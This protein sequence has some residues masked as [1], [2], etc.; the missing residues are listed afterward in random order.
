MKKRSGWKLSSIG[1]FYLL[2]IGSLTIIIQLILGA[3]IIILGVAI[4]IVL[5]SL[6]EIWINDINNIGAIIVF[7]FGTCTVTFG[8][9]LKTILFQRL[10]SNLYDPSLAFFVVLIGMIEIV[11]A[12]TIVNRMYINPIFKPCID[13][14]TLDLIGII[15]FFIGSFT[16]L[17]NQLYSNR[18]TDFQAD[19]PG[20]G[21]FALFRNL[22]ILSVITITASTLLKTEGRKILS[23]RLII[24]SIFITLM[25][26]IDNQKLLLLQPFLAFLL[27]IFFFRK[28]KIPFQFIYGIIGI[29][30][31]VIFISPMV[32]YFRY[33][34]I[35]GQTLENK[36]TLIE[37]TITDLGLP[38]LLENALFYTKVTYSRGYYDYFGGNGQFQMIGGRFASIQQI[39]PIIEKIKPGSY[40]GLEPLSIAVQSII[41]RIIFPNKDISNDAYYIIQKLGL[42]SQWS[43]Y[44]TVPIIAIAYATLGIPGLLVIPLIIFILFFIEIKIIGWHLDRNI[45]AI[46]IL[47]FMFPYIHE[48]S[49]QQ[50]YV[51]I[52]REIPTLIIIIFLIS[53]I[54][55]IKF[56]HSY[57]FIPQKS[58]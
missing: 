25:A 9:L 24:I 40:I 18:I 51:K 13:P 39:D 19:D 6:I 12:F 15:S 1:I 43:T 4:F 14:R 53:A 42:A 54:A 22:L 41:P 50:Y 11:I 10:D 37:N 34:G 56:H 46:F 27:T 29:G 8:I 26:F 23:I 30:L 2:L 49:F 5:F 16:W 38:K 20:L 31:I 44:P 33:I 32:T 48:G 52:F 47:C 17:L 35:Q 7:L 45:Y 55:K 36:I 3:N 57:S 58:E 21:G 28:G